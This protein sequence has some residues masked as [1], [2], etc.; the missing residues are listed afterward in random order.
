MGARN[1]IDGGAG[2]D[3][4]TGAGEA[5]TLTGGEGA[6]Q[7]FGN[8]GADILRGG[9]GADILNGGAGLD[10]MDGG[11]GDDVFNDSFG[12]GFNIDGGAGSDRLTISGG[13][14]NQPVIFSLAAAIAS[15]SVLTGV[16]FVTIN[17]N[18]AD[19]R[20]TGAD[21]ADVLFGNDGNDVLTGLGGNDTLY[22][23]RGH[24][25]MDGGEGNDFIVVTMGSTF[26]ADGGAGSDTLQFSAD[27]N[28]GV[29][30]SLEAALAGGS[31]YRNV[32][33]IL[34]VGSSGGDRL[35]GSAE[36]DFIYAYGGNDILLAG[37]GNDYLL[38]DAGYDYVE[39]GT[40]DD[41]IDGG[42][43]DD[44]LDAGSGTDFVVGG[45]G[46]DTLLIG[47][48]QSD[49]AVTYQG[50]Q[51]IITAAGIR[52]T[53]NSG[54]EAVRFADQIVEVGVDG[55]LMA[56][57]F[58]NGTAGADT[59]ANGAGADNVIGG[60]GNDILMG[61]AG[62]DFLNGGE[63]IDAAA[64]SSASRRYNIVGNTV[65]GGPEGGADTLTAIE[66]VRFV[67]GVRTF[68]VNSQAAQIMRLY[69][70]A[71]DRAPDQ[72]G[73]ESVLDRLESGQ[74]LQ[75]VAA[76][77]LA[78]PEFQS[79]YGALNNQQFIEQLYRFC[80]NREGDA[81]GI[82]NWVN[83]LNSGVGRTEMLVTFSESVEHRNLTQGA[84]AQGLWV[85]DEAALKIAR[86]Y[87]AT[88]DRLPD[89]GGL[90]VWTSTLKGG[91]SMIDIATAFAGSAEFQQRY[92]AVTNEQFIRQ[93]YQFCLNRE[94]DAAG[95]AT[96]TEQLSAGTSRAQMLLNFSESAEHVSLT[97]ASWIGGVSLSDP[98]PTTASPVTESK[99]S[100]PL[101]LPDWEDG[102]DL[103]N[104][105]PGASD[106]GYASFDGAFRAVD[107]GVYSWAADRLSALVDP[108]THDW[109]V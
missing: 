83:V 93:M 109:I 15:G 51:I 13:V 9:A 18:S 23:G 43:N 92:G 31:T 87:D 27:S 90:G 89:A 91:M 26:A 69:D 48:R 53:I 17:G 86:M 25:I 67:D 5:D 72:D 79:R 107:E 60:A 39:G 44:A 45:A 41:Y 59:L 100:H 104:W 4:L 56:A 62:S 33:T 102:F 99:D 22:G 54:I 101:I 88:F 80:L 74:S 36:R 64:Y 24:N 66:E 98:L 81:A 85:A 38:G 6:D 35:T 77:F 46:L 30:F 8:D 37:A 47:L 76:I 68:D 19:D 73:F 97:R 65:I 103:D 55:R 1:I 82:Q 40:G 21:T 84:L 58:V 2:D 42:A 14:F 63:G 16:E 108:G 49:V 96:W 11:D 95:L 71:L 50:S 61:G 78:S 3:R 75:Q 57:R 105:L 20:L 12:D 52:T 70:A 32:E 10:V 106:N 29:T 94:P 28:G 34:L 7:L